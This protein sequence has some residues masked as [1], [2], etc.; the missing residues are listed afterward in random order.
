MLKKRSKEAYKRLQPGTTEWKAYWKR[1][2]DQQK[3]MLAYRN[4]LGYQS[5]ATGKDVSI[6]PVMPKLKKRKKILVKTPKP[7]S[8]YSLK[9]LLPMIKKAVH[10][11]IGK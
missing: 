2:P 8:S 4:K 5:L 10:K 9:P 1:H 6:K 7:K 3:D 11:R